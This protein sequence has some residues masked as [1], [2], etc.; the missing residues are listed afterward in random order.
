MTNCC[1]VE[2]STARAREIGMPGNG[3]RLI[4]AGVD[5]AGIRNRA[6]PSA[7]Q[8]APGTIRQK[9][10]AQERMADRKYQHNARVRCAWVI[11]CRYDFREK[12]RQRS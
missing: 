3:L 7:T 10:S 5:D 1:A 6:A 11:I 4:D 9:L 12:P 2:S 8:L